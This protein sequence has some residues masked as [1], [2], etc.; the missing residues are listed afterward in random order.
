[1]SRRV[2]EFALLIGVVL[3]LSAVVFGLLFGLSLLDVV[4]LAAVGTYPF[5]AFG[6]LRDDDPAA[7]VPARWILAGGV[8]WAF[9]GVIGVLAADPSPSALVPAAFAGL[10]LVLPPAAYAVRHGANVNPLP[11]RATLAAG[12][13]VGVGLLALGLVTV[14]PVLGTVSAVLAAV[15][16][17]LYATARGVRL[18]E[19]TRRAGVAAGALLGVAVV[20]LGVVRGDELT[21]W[22]LAGVAVAFAPSLYVVLSRNRSRR[23]RRRTR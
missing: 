6:L 10:V 1:M 18:A 3:G 4:V 19:R 14:Q 23:G 2:P 22:V 11:P 13:A 17:G 8:L 21:N 9:L 12:I 15:A 20:A 16:A 7:V 5:A